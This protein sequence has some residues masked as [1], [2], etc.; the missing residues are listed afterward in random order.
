MNTL[1]NSFNK[2][3]YI[4][5]ARFSKCLNISLSEA[6]A[7]RGDGLRIR[8]EGLRDEG[9]A[10][11]LQKGFLRALRRVMFVRHKNLSGE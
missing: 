4:Q 2:I 5:Y 3:T 10:R 9:R 11:R 1:K 7:S 6:G 8:C